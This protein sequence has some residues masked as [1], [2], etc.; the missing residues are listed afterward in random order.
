MFFP[1]H[2]IVP[3]LLCGQETRDSD[4]RDPGTTSASARKS[5]DA[6]GHMEVE[7]AAD[8]PEGSGAV[9]DS[10]E[11]EVETPTAHTSKVHTNKQTALV[12]VR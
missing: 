8:Q 9:D 11:M 4:M 12:C 10:N 1:V 6:E 3:V 5:V 2:H 7:A